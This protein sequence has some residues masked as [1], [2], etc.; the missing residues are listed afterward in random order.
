MPNA[1]EMLAAETISFALADEQLPSGR[2]TLSNGTQVNRGDWPALVFAT[3]GEDSCSGALIGP[4]ILLTAAHCVEDKQ[5]K[6]RDAMLERLGKR[7][8]MLCERHPTYVRREL[9][10]DASS[11]RGAE[12]Y[13]LCIIDYRGDVP[14][15]IADMRF[16][17]LDT[18]STLARRSPVLLTGYG[19][20]DV[21]IVNRKIVSTASAKILRIG[22]ASIARGPKR[23]LSDGAYALIESTGKP[24]P[25]LCP[26]DSGGPMFLGVSALKP[27][28]SR[29]IAG[30]NSA[31][32]PGASG[33]TDHI[34]SKIAATG[35][36][37][38]REWIR[39]WQ[40]RNARQA[41]IVC[42]VTRDAGTFPCRS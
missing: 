40:G 2:F 29:R 30:V 3:F 11:P 4:N 16:E 5:G 36:A 20:I 26:G 37:T 9:V 24:T 22:D 12:D 25:A 10:R 38:F 17:V 13:A 28:G 34:V 31:I 41:P 42:G 1:T 21:R 14:K 8:P 15:A 6:P 19:C 39:E 32:A 35:T 23:R 27:T 33:R 7:F 18:S